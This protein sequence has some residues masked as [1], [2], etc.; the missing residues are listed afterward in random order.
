MD[1]RPI[2]PAEHPPLTAPSARARSVAVRPTRPGDWLWLTRL[3]LSPELV[4]RQYHW[5]ET[6]LQLVIAPLRGAVLPPGPRC[7]IE[8]DG[9]RAGYIGRNPLSGN[10]EY[11]L[12]PWARGGTGNQ[13]ITAFLRDHRAGDRP[14]AFFVSHRNPRSLAALHRALG[15]LG[16]VEG[17]QFH[18]RDGRH[19]WRI[20]VEGTS[21]EPEL[22]MPP[23]QARSRPDPG[24]GE[25][26]DPAD[27]AENGA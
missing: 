7:T 9:R 10:L 17:R 24:A 2:R 23:D 27:P 15:D 6:P 13:A 22:E 4:G 20:T 11:T 26:N 18:T 3:G 14:R 8:V 21:A 1:R 12:Q 16:W 25:P 5:A 19:G